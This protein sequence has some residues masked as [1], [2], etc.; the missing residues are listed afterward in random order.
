[1]ETLQFAQFSG[2]KVEEIDIGEVGC[3]QAKSFL[4][5]M[6]GEI[7]QTNLLGG[8][9]PTPVVRVDQNGIGLLVDPSVQMQPGKRD[10]GCGADISSLP[11]VPIPRPQRLDV[12]VMEG[13]GEILK[14]K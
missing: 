3:S 7:A 4:R 6:N 11:S 13:C 14:G 10:E 2:E 1:M 8:R 12:G 5:R 9:S